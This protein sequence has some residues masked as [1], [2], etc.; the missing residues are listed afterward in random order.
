MPSLGQPATRQWQCLQ[1]MFF[2]GGLYWQ[3]QVIILS[4]GCGSIGGVPHQPVNPPVLPGRA[5]PHLP[6]QPFNIQ[7]ALTAPSLQAHA[8]ASPARSH[9]PK[10]PNPA[11]Q[12][13]THPHC[14]VP[15]SLCLR[16]SSSPALMADT[17]TTKDSA[18]VPP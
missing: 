5:Y 16:Q 12:H 17:A 11:L 9:L 6:I 10:P 8:S 4:L 3:Y 14:P 1:T 2:D 15:T 7:P 18:A 13:P